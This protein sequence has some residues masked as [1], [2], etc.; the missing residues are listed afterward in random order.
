VRSTLL[1]GLLVLGQATAARGQ[2]DSLLADAVRLA[3]QGQSDSARALVRNRIARLSP[4]DS[5]YPE[6]LYAAGVVAVDADSALA[7]LRRVSIEFS[8]SEWADQALLR[9]AQISYA[10]GQLRA[11]ARTAE[12]ILLDY[13]FSELLGSAAYWSGMAHLELGELDEGCQM[14]RQ[15]ETRAGDDMELLN[16]AQYALQRCE[17][18]EA[19]TPEARPGTRV[20]YAV[21]VAAV[22]SA[23][24]ADEIM[25][26][27]HTRGYDSHVVRDADGLLKVRVG[28][29]AAKAE[30][31]NLA[32]QLRREIGGRPFVVEER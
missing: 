4:A 8:A 23:A 2:S 19:G 15:A 29:F 24:A 18:A 16:R 13:P 9:M 28:R 12:R 17:A 20:V 25:Q 26:D 21:Q 27:L 7:Y 32:A 3:S 22:Q 11:T 10:R 6:A 14:L 30:A 31:D 1:I 5:L